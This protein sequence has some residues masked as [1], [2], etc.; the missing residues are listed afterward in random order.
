[1]GEFKNSRAY[2]TY[3][4]KGNIYDKNVREYPFF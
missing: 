3:D 1:M 4:N 2:P